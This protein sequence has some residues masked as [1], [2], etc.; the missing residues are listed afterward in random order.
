LHHQEN[1]VFLTLSDVKFEREI[2]RSKCRMNPGRST[3]EQNHREHV[4]M[5]M[6]IL[7]SMHLQ[8]LPLPARRTVTG[9]RVSRRQAQSILV[10]VHTWQVTV[11]LQELRRLATFDSGGKGFTIN[12]TRKITTTQ[13]LHK[14]EYT[15]DS[16][17]LR[18]FYISARVW[19]GMDLDWMDRTDM[20]L[21][22]LRW[23]NIGCFA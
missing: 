2:T 13:K 4:R 16:L 17:V 14:R 15:H 19:V 12:E 8:M 22:G 6:K 1:N 20:A 23:S 18:S 5:A 21:Y 9:Y 10:V 3:S 11:H 7:V